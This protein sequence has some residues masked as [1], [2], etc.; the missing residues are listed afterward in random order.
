MD[1]PHVIASEVAEFLKRLESVPWFD[2][3]GKAITEGNQAGRILQHRPPGSQPGEVAVPTPQILEGVRRPHH[4]RPGPPNLKTI[5]RGNRPF[6]L[7]N[8]LSG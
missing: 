5:Q 2:N 4:S 8:P 3:I 1:S 7:L 6:S